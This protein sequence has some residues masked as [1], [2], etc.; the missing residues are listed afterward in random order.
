[1]Q[2]ERAS[3]LMDEQGV[4]SSLLFPTVAVCVEHFMKP[5]IPEQ[6]Y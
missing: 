1:M 5:T 2:R 3:P 6:M 4:E